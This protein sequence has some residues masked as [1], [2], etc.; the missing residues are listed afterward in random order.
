MIDRLIDRRT[1]G[2]VPPSWGWA[3]APKLMRGFQVSSLLPRHLLM[4]VGVSAVAVAL[5]AIAWKFG[6]EEWADPWLPGE[7][8]V[9]SDAERW[10]FVVVCT[11]FSM[12]AM[13]LPALAVLRL[14]SE[15]LSAARLSRDVFTLAPQP[16]MVTTPGGRI[17]AVNRAWEAL[18][19]KRSAQ[20]VGL[21]VPDGCASIAESTVL[22]RIGESVDRVGTWAGEAQY[23][24][25]NA[26]RWIWLSAIRIT[27]RETEDVHHVWTFADITAR[28]QRETSAEHAALHDVLTGLPNRRLLGQRLERALAFY[29]QAGG[30]FAV[31]FIDLDG[32]KPVND[33]LGHEAGDHVLR[34]AAERLRGSARAEDTVA[35]VGG[36]EFVILAGSLLSPADAAALARRCIERFA[37]GFPTQ[38]GGAVTLGASIGIA[39][40]TPA[41]ED[42]DSLLRAADEAMY[43]AKRAGGR[44]WS[45]SPLA[46]P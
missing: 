41:V 2:D 33:R 8:Q 27:G 43:V 18:L 10:E 17:L 5:L 45:F 36:D 12:L 40:A 24:T 1:R 22:R 28:K 32:F 35:R 11:G 4:F 21:P 25:A 42:A 19:G 34:E 26:S 46:A 30:V 13:V 9:E 23:G 31:L 29:R 39:L 15:N 37:A 14:L 7:H 38:G 20:V 16:M 3:S 44:Q 6:L